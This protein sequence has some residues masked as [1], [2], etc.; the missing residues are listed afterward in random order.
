VSLSGHNLLPRDLGLLS[1]IGLVPA[2]LGMAGGQWV[3]RRISETLF[4]T[5]LY[6][7]L[8]VLGIYLAVRA[9]I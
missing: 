5:V 1:T 8:A 7:S 3:R 6:W 4:R 9:F 2:L